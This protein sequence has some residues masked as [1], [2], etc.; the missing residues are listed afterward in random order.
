MEFTTELNIE[1]CL[2]KD[3]IEYLNLKGVSYIQDQ[4]AIARI[5]WICDIEAKVW[6]IKSISSIVKKVSI[7]GEVEYYFDE[8]E[9][10]EELQ[11]KEFE[12][13]GFSIEC[14]LKAVDNTMYPS[15][16]EIDFKN[17]KIIIT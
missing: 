9:E 12:I 7:I 4:K 2:N 6:G 10:C 8:D 5:E 11:T 3:L 15:N 16:V 17:K 1:R 13:K 14:D